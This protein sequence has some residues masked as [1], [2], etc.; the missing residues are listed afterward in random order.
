[1]KDEKKPLASAPISVSLR[2]SSQTDL[3]AL[4][5]TFKPIQGVAAAIDLP[6]NLPLSSVAGKMTFKG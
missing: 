6:L 4:D 2:N 1:M 3:V 5:L